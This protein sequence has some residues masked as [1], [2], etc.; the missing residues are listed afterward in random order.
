MAEHNELYRNAMYYDIALQRD[1]SPDVEFLCDACRHYAGAA[2]HSVLDIACGPGYHAREFARRGITAWGLDLRPEMVQFAT[3][4]AAAEGVQVHWLAADMRSFQLEAPVDL[5]ICMFDGLD[6]LTA[7]EDILRHFQ[8]VAANLTPGGLYI[9]EF[10]HPHRVS[11]VSYG[12]FHYHGERGGVT[13]D[14]TWATNNPV[15]DLVTGVAY[16]EIRI[17]VDEHGEKKI[18]P[19]SATERIFTPQEL[20]L[21]AALSG[22]FDVVGWHGDFNL[23]Q[24]LDHTAASQRMVLVMRKVG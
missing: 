3:D 21:L 16:V 5:A 8:T 14:I 12:P 2:P 1:V 19:D 17:E 15:H 11:L 24:P 10:S 20:T 13:V 9:L 23:A 4:Q 18:I 7:T 6:A 22:V